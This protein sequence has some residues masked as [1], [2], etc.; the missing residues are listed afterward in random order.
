[1]GS[2]PD[3]NSTTAWPTRMPSVQAGPPGNTSQT[4]DPDPP[5]A[6]PAS[7]VPQPAMPAAAAL[8]T[9]ASTMSASPI[10]R[11]DIVDNFLLAGQ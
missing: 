2:T 1:V 7:G 8:K 10:S 6:T 4:L 3:F 9:A 11:P 5:A